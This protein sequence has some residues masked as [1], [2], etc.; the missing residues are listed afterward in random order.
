MAMARNVGGEN[1]DLAVRDLTRRAGILSRYAARGVALFQ[2]AGFVDHQHCIIVSQMLDNII[3]HQ[4]AQCGRIPTVSAQ[5]FL[6]TPR[7]RIA[8]GLRAHPSGLAPLLAKQP[9]DKQARARRRPL[10]RKQRTHPSLHVPK[11]RCPQLKR[12][13]DRGPGHP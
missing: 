11:R 10:L 7:T 13:L 5:K 4:I 2:K 1:A 12:R 9:V 8:R 6:L 3:A